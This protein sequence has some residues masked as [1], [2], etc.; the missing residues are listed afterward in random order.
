L[1]VEEVE[2]VVEVLFFGTVVEVLTVVDEEV[3]DDV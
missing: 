3:V 1:E 2:E